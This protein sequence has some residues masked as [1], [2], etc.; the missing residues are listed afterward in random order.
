METITE[1]TIGPSLLR[2]NEKSLTESAEVLLFIRG[3][4]VTPLL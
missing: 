2:V 4:N 1:Q 3:K